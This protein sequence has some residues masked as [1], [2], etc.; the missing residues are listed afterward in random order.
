MLTIKTPV[1]VFMFLLSV[2]FIFC[3]GL[4]YPLS[5]IQKNQSVVIE[6]NLLTT[7]QLIAGKVDNW[8]DQSLQSSAMIT[9]VASVKAMDAKQQAPLL[10]AALETSESAS[11][12]FIT[13]TNGDAVARSDDKALRNYSEREYIQQVIAGAP[14]GQQVLIGTAKPIPLYC[15]ALPINNPDLVGVLTQ[16][17]G[18][19]HITDFVISQRIG[20][21]GLAFLVD[22]KNRLVAH[23]NVRDLTA[24]LQD[25]SRHPALN[26]VNGKTLRVVDVEGKKYIFV[27]KAVGLNWKVVVQQDDHEAYSYNIELQKN[28]IILCRL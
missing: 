18:L 17:A 7:A 26:N 21:T 12:F 1:K 27:V 15:F 5:T 3:L 13:D 8:L 23:G 4:W 25:F 6:H 24:K 11:V 22:N 20:E 2:A 16:C 9:N 10:L 14:V 19:K 28:P